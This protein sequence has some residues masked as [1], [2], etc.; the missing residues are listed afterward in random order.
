MLINC[1]PHRS[2]VPVVKVT[3]QQ[4][5]KIDRMDFRTDASQSDHLTDEGLSDESP[6]TTPPNFS[7]ASDTTFHT[8]TAILHL[9]QGLWKSPWTF[10]IHRAGRH[11]SQGLVRTHSIVASQPQGRAMLLTS[12]RPSGWAG[13]FSFHDPMK[14]LVRSIV[15]RTPGPRKFHSYPQPYPPGTQT[16]KTR[17][18][19]GSKRTSIVHPNHFRQ[20]PLLKKC[21]KDGLDRLPMLTDQHSSQQAITTVQI[22]DGQRFATLSIAG[23]KP[24]LEVYCPNVIGPP[25]PRQPCMLTHAGFARSPWQPAS[26][27][28]SL[29]PTANGS[30]AGRSQRLPLKLSV[31]FLGSP[32]RML[33]AHL[34]YALD[35]LVCHSCWHSSWPS[36]PVL[37]CSTT[38]LS[39]ARLPFVSCLATDAEK[40]A[41]LKQGLFLPEQSLYQTQPL[42][43]YRSNLP[44]HAAEKPLLLPK[45]CYPC[46]VSKVSPMC[47]P[48][49]ERR[50][51][52][53][54]ALLRSCAPTRW[55]MCFKQAWATAK[56]PP[57]PTPLL[58]RRRGGTR[59]ACFPFQDPCKV[60]GKRSA[61]L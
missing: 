5:C 25:R 60:Q 34:P 10:P 38:A 26:Q 9:R 55:F 18:P 15:L 28:Q 23:T 48:R 24:T 52:T 33:F 43:N 21:S 46:L 27:T 42:P 17:R 32:I 13:G 1:W 12:S 59:P 35:P 37:Q 41:Y 31:D 14:L 58:Q 16:R 49:A 29:E 3:D 54:A 30:C 47:C 50:H 53:F 56:R 6:A 57:L 39:K 8:T 2:Y 40:T 7:I 61:P 19:S 4:S 22:P 20:S 36:G 44:R 11:L 51:R 45:K